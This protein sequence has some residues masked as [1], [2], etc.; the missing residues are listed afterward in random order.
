MPKKQKRPKQGVDFDYWAV[1]YISPDGG[2]FYYTE[3]YPSKQQAKI[4]TKNFIPKPGRL[5]FIRVK[6]MEVN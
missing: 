4:G 2:W 5:E 3:C 6:F 1:K